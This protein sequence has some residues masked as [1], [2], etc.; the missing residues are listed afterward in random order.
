MKFKI[1]MAGANGWG[2]VKSSYDGGPYE[3][4]LFSSKKD[5]KTEIK[6]LSEH[7]ADDI[8]NYRIVTKETPSDID[9]YN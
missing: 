3:V 9:F 8:S 7:Y 5:A 1:Q 6:D 4:D 2:D